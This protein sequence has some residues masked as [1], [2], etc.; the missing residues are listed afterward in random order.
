MFWAVI[1]RGRI[2]SKR[3]QEYDE[4]MEKIAKEVYRKCPAQQV[5]GGERRSLAYVLK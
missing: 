4:R 1:E 2:V 5:K 3:I